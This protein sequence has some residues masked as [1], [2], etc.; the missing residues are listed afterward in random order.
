MNDILSDDAKS[1]R[2]IRPKI[3]NITY[4]PYV[5]RIKKNDN[6]VFLNLSTD[7]NEIFTSLQNLFGSLG[8]QRFFMRYYYPKRFV[9]NNPFVIKPRQMITIDPKVKTQ[10]VTSHIKG[11]KGI[12][13]NKLMDRRNTIL[14]Y[15]DLLKGLVPTDRNTLVKQ[16]VIDYIEN[17]YP[18]ILCYIL[19]DN[20]KHDKSND[21][22]LDEENQSKENLYEPIDENNKDYSLKTPFVNELSDET[23]NKLSEMIDSG[24]SVE[25]FTEVLFSKTKVFALSGPAFGVSKFGFD[26]Y[27]IS[28]PFRLTK[29]NL[30]DKQHITGAVDFLR[31]HKLDPDLIYPLSIIKLIYLCYNAFINGSSDNEF[32]NEVIKYNVT[33]HIYSEN[34]TG[35]CLN[36]KELRDDLHFTPLR[37][38]MQLIIRLKLLC[39]VNLGM[40]TE[41]DLDKIENDVD[42]K[43]FTEVT[44]NAVQDNTFIA[45][46]K[47][48]KDLKP[49]VDNDVVISSIIDAKIA[50][51]TN[52]TKENNVVEDVYKDGKHVSTPVINGSDIDLASASLLNS[53]N[54]V[55]AKTK[56]TKIISND[57]DEP[58][59]ELDDKDIGEILDDSADTEDNQEPAEEN[60]DNS[61]EPTKSDEEET[62]SE[63]TSFGDNYDEVSEEQPE[64]QTSDNSFDDE[65]EDTSEDNILEDENTDKNYKSSPVNPTGPT[66]LQPV[67]KYVVKRGDKDQKRINLIKDKYKSLQIDG[68]KI[69]KIIGNSAKISIDNDKKLGTRPP[70]T[71]DP[72][73]VKMNLSNFTSAYVKNNYQAD[74]VNSVRALSVN[75]EVPLYM[76][77]AD[78]K[79]TSDQFTNKLTYSFTLEDEF[80]K[81]H[82]LKFDVPKL[83]EHGFIKY[84]G[85][86]AYIKKQ[87]IRKPIVKIGPDK[88]YITT[89][90]NAYQVFRSGMVLNKGSEV[91]RRILSEFY[92]DN[93]NVKIERGNCEDDNTNYI[94]TLE[95]DALAKDYFNVNINASSKYGSHVVIYFSQKIIRDKIKQFS[96]KTGFK[97]DIIPD[98]ILPL[99]INYTDLT[100]YSIDVKT[101]SS[102]NSTIINIFNTVL[103]DDNL[104]EFVKKI[105]TPKKRI[106]SKVEIQSF[107]VP[108]IAF[109]NYTFGWEKVKSYFPENAIEFSKT[110]LDKTNKLSIKFY[111]G[112]LYYNQYPINGAILLNGLSEIDTENYNY[113]DL[114]NQALYINFTYN[115]YKTRN[116]VKG[117]VT[118]KECMLDY[119]TLQILE[120]MNLPT[121]LL[122]IFLYCNDLLVD[123]QCKPESD[124]SNYRIR[125][126]E[127]ISQCLYSAL[128][129]QYNVYKKR[130]GKR[131]SMT[132]PPNIVMTKVYKTDIL[133]NYDSISPISEIRNEGI[134]TFKGPGGTKLEQ[135]I[136]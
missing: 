58:P 112:Y 106:M 30:L 96:I 16:K 100:L 61:V 105:K 9:F 13:R 19:F 74:I 28:V 38:V 103:P 91:V 60:E 67:E 21:I 123:N 127:I 131:I 54:A 135:E 24:A 80:K 111:D 82:N 114:N 6:T 34:G 66:K 120:S 118:V 48:K 68:Q 53:V 70:R 56:I 101:N 83:D 37:F 124:I 117:W 119:K 29:Y 47:L 132:I 25:S 77:K 133:G 116:I 49:I 50:E 104:I 2:I 110:R 52:D 41:Q 7:E 3:K 63:N 4:K 10:L 87:L 121:D 126:N 31:L 35:F 130:S 81:K 5:A 94:T 86:R 95:Y 46:D 8:P 45:K 72:S 44:S 107:K 62:P 17:I 26:K 84:R 20:T 122:E 11:F 90:L 73:V 51:A 125:D 88:V 23:W 129:D 22:E 39:M 32:V 128:T 64:E 59:I 12:P 40:V 115:K 36:L 108:L 27:I 136:G 85:S 134:T 1:F 18:E 33:F 109:L 92:I 93:K 43:E 75:K 55:K 99:A 97:D 69:E 65:Y 14:D 15:T 113:E 76:T 42:N 89:Q 98:N 57:P 78:V 102:I 71:A 79:D